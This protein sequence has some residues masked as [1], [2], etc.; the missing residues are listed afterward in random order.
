MNN[1]NNKVALQEAIRRI[2]SYDE[3]NCQKLLR[4]IR[5]DYQRRSPYIAYLIRCRQSLLSTIAQFDNILAHLRQDKKNINHNLVNLCVRYY[6]ESK[7]ASL[8]EFIEQFKGTNVS[9]EKAQLVEE[10]LFSLF[11][12]MET[13]S[14][15]QIASEEQV[16]HG[17]KL[18]ERHVT[19]QIYIY[20]LYPN[21]DGDVLRD[22]I[23]QQHIDNLSKVITP[24]HNDL[25]I[26]NIYHSE[27][28]WPAAQQQII[29]LN[30]YKTPREKVDCVIKCC[31]I[32]MSLLKLANEKSIPTADD[33][34]PVLVYILI[35]ANPSS[36]LSNVQY[37]ECFYEKQLKGEP[38]Y[39]WTQFSSAVG[40]VKT[41]DY[42]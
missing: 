19:S 2:K 31:K 24:E 3:N 40:F 22:Q 11:K 13:D 6:L 14:V 10:F 27:C 39:W 34:I 25:R 8:K 18:I 9:D 33:L 35:K 30:A 28:P 29:I 38:A 23:L 20:A 16:E 17:K 32:I 4:S 42:A 5:E 15:W 1:S 12:G 26:P 41:M 36:L 21:G 37:V 7:E